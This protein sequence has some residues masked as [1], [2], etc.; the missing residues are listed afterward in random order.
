M[1]Q[2]MIDFL[3]NLTEAH[4]AV[5]LTTY[6]VYFGGRPATVTVADRGPDGGDTRFYVEAVWSDRTEAELASDSGRTHGNPAAT[7]AEA[8]DQPHWW[9]FAPE[10][11]QD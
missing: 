6:E 3:N 9:I 2:Q 5:H 4:S 11:N 7:L 8:L 10:N 1:H